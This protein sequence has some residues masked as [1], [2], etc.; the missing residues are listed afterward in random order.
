MEINEILIRLIHTTKEVEGFDF[1]MGEAELTKTEFRLIREDILER[2]K[3]GE[4]ISSELAKRLG[5]TRSAISQIVMKLENKGIVKR[6]PS[7]TDKKIAY[8]RLSDAAESA[9]ERHCLCANRF[10]QEVISEFGEERMNNLVAEYDELFRIM[11]KVKKNKAEGK[12][13]EKC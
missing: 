5:V 11:D 2:K 1:F 13:A 3:G 10:M 6:V 8:V 4:I 7:K 12:Q 9:F